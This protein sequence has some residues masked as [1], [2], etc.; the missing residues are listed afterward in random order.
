MIT[1]SRIARHV[2]LALPW[3]AAACALAWLF[4]W[5]F[6]PTGIFVAERVGLDPNPWIFSFLPADRTEPR[7]EEG[8]VRI[9]GDP[10]YLNVQS[11]GPYPKA[12]VE[13]DYRPL[14]QPLL[15]FGPSVGAGLDLRPMYAEELASTAF[16]PAEAGGRSG[17]VRQGTPASRLMDPD[18]SGLATWGATSTAPAL[19]DPAAATTTDVAVNLRGAHDFHL[20][21]AGGRL[22]FA[23]DL[24]AA[25]R[26]AGGDVAVLRLYRGD[27][28]LSRDAV[29]LSGS[30]DVRLGSVVRAEVRLDDA[31]PGVYRIALTAK[32]EV[33]VRRIRTDA[34]RW[35]VGPRLVFG[36]A[37]GFS[38][39]T[40]PAVAW[41][42]SRHFVFETFHREGL[43][44][45]SVENATGDFVALARTHAA[46][47]L[48]RTDVDPAPVRVVAPNG[49]VRWLGDGYFSFTKEA[50]FEPKPRRFSDGT[51]LDAEGVRAV[52]TPYRRPDDVGGGW[53]RSRFSVD[54]D[55]TQASTRFVLAAPGIAD[56]SGG[57]DIRRVRVVFRRPAAS[58]ADWVKIL[59]QELAN[60]WHRL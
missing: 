25:N 42:T 20:V 22:R 52:L 47:R 36:D 3:L 14:R 31:K 59:R 2:L 4:L 30:R 8:A 27:T 43:G 15:E 39:S 41:T 44:R 45:I 48:D 58:F 6:P 9:V 1:G 40:A 5:R 50:F 17:F 38:T 24:Q 55:P 34:R 49:D 26:S 12:E 56:R 54:L 32:D 11:P 18:P 33:F 37:V 51:R 60:A 21:P 46:W 29:T 10:V 23:L 13:I 28:E 53:R 19:S 16:V 7:P 57:V 35:V